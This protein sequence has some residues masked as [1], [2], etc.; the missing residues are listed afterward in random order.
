[1]ERDLVLAIGE[2]IQQHFEQWVLDS[3]CSYHMCPHRHWF[4]TYEKKFGG[5]VLI[6]N[7]APC[8]F[9]NIVSIQIKMHDGI[10]RAL[11]EVRHMIEK[12]LNHA[13]YNSISTIL[14]SVVKF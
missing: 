8:K 4:V 6:G 13:Q 10:I 7:D 2:Q 12:G 1:M 3:G 14:C 11:I 5:N 9:V